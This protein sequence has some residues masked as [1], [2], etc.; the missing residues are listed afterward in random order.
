MIADFQSVDPGSN[1]GCDIFF[2]CCC[3]CKRLQCCS[4]LRNELSI[5]T[6]FYLAKGKLWVV[7][8]FT[9]AKF[10]EI[11]LGSSLIDFYNLLLLKYK[12]NRFFYTN[13]SNSYVFRLIVAKNLITYNCLVINIDLRKKVS[14]SLNCWLYLSEQS[15]WSSGYDLRPS[16]WWPGF[17]PRMRCFFKVGIR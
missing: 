16:T 1:P 10:A 17:K 11:L 3:R 15:H 7:L 9:L 14:V 5:S 13:I 2:Y 8:Q 12:L 4:Y 6:R